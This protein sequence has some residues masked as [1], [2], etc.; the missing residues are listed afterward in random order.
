MPL[1]TTVQQKQQHDH[2]ICVYDRTETITFR[3]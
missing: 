3:V 1:Q 2:T